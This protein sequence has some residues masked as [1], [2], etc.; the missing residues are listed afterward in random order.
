MTTNPK[1]Y[2]KKYYHKNRKHLIA[3]GK[4]PV[5]CKYCDITIKK[6]HMSKHKKSKRHN[7][8]KQI[9]ELKNDI[10]K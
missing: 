10:S 3:M 1:G 2:M 5:I 8:M 4:V 9:Y 7:L 6:W